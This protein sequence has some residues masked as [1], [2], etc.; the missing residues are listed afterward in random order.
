M[1]V[2]ATSISMHVNERNLPRFITM[3]VKRTCTNHDTTKQSGFDAV[4]IGS[5]LG[6]ISP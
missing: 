5:V 2:V 3:L 6:I 4:P 1:K